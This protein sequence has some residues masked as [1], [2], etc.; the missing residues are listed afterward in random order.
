MTK[1]KKI[2]VNSIQEIDNKINELKLELAK[3][4]G[5]L[6]SKTKVTNTSKKKEMQ[7]EIARLFTLKNS[8]LKKKEG[9]KAA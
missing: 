3:Y 9:A 1:K 8:L 7:K 4:K 5:M 2:E 6:V